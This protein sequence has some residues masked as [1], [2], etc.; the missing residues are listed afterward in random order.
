[1]MT[2]AI[3]AVGTAIAW[4]NQIEIRTQKSLNDLPCKV[5]EIN[6]T[7]D[8]NL[9]TFALENGEYGSDTIY[10]MPLKLNAR[11]FVQGYE[12]TDFENMLNDMQFS[13]DFIEIKSLNG[14]KYKN[15]KI[16]SWARDT[17]SQMVGATYYN[18]SLQ[19]FIIVDSLVATL[20]KGKGGLG[21]AEGTG[22]KAP[23]EKKISTLKI[24]GDAVMKIGR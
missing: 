5:T 24:I 4:F 23:Q 16:Q 20:A 2:L 12:Y 1:M 6:E 11:L 19:E 17:T 15:L 7:Q 22:N 13:E 14:K 8:Y 10:R 3:N 9:P 21:S 18:V